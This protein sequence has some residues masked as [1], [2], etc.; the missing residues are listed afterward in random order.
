MLAEACGAD[1]ARIETVKAYQGS[2][3]EVVSQGQK[4]VDAGFLPKIKAIDKAIADYDVIAIGTPTWWYTMAPAV[5]TFLNENDFSKKTVIP[6]MT[7]AGWSGTVIRDM[8]KECN[9]EK[10]LMDQEFTFSSQKNQRTLMMTED[11]VL[12]KWIQNILNYLQ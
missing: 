12:K 11:V 6:F 10:V 1:I 5:H 2:Y 9:A 3:D 7:N 8:K 4:E